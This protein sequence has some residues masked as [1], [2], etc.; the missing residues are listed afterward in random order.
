MGFVGDDFVVDVVR[1]DGSRVKART[2][3]ATRTAQADANEAALRSKIAQALAANQAFLA[4]PTPNQNQILAHLR[5]MTKQQSAIMRL[6]TNQLDD[7]A[8]T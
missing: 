8:D 4:I 5:A 6:L 1:E 2:P 7:I 3:L